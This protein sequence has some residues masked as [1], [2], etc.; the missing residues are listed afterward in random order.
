VLLQALIVIA[1]TA[2]IN[3][4][5]FRRFVRWDLSRSQTFA[6]S[7]QTKKRARQPAKAGEG[8]HLFL[9]R[10]RHWTDLPDVT[11]LLRE[12]D[13]AS[14]GKLTIEEVNPYG[15]SPVPRNSR[16]NTVSAKSRTS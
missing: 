16:S 3:Y 8:H 14:K 11:G 6:L 7:E 12:Y 1:I 2:A 5:G 10:G 15:T 9:R 13:Y 4:I